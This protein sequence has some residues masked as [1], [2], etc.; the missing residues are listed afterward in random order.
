[1]LMLRR[2]MTFAYDMPLYRPPSEADNLIIQ[3]TIG[4]SFNRCGFCAMYRAKSFR[5]RPLQEVLQ[6]IRK[7][8]SIY[9]DVRR[10]FLADGDALVLP[11]EHLLTILRELQQSF[12]RLSRVS[13]YAT[14]SNLLHKSEEE[15]I[16]LKAN[17]LSLLYLGIESGSDTVL[18]MVVKG[19]SSKG[20]I[21]ALHKAHAVGMKVSA[22]VI[23][24]IAGKALWQEHIDSTIALLNEAPVAYLSTLQLHLEPELLADY[25]KAFDGHFMMSDDKDM[26]LEQ[27]QLI[28]GLK[29]PIPV[30]FRS[31]H[32]SNA[33]ALAGVLPRD[34]NKLLLELE[35]AL[36]GNVAL[37]PWFIRGM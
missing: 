34:Q 31:N 7:L 16:A 17:K 12:P 20:I 14:P 13:C 26:L 27:Q 29:P 23:L 36:N 6:E 25:E 15:L 9:P 35:S 30:I 24:G 22:T 33:L 28:E 37:R 8:C 3:V 10:I 19:A 4:C 5:I 2:N 21:K 1:M 18:R 32:A 11:T